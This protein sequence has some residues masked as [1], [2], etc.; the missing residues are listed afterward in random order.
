MQLT[1][2]PLR[3]LTNKK[4]RKYFVESSRQRLPPSVRRLIPRLT[5]PPKQRVLDDK[6]NQQQQQQQQRQ[7]SQ[8]S[9]LSKGVIMHNS[10]LKVSCY[11]NYNKFVVLMLH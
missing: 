3:P 10:V 4:F 7:K 6:N 9:L 5:G 8:H 1:G 11:K 2:T